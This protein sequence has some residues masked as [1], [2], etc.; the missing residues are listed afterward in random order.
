[1]RSIQILEIGDPEV[2]TVSDVPVPVP[3]IAGHQF[4]LALTREIPEMTS[5]SFS[6]YR[7]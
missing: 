5:K 1:M 2:M 3:A 4:Y 6:S 7:G